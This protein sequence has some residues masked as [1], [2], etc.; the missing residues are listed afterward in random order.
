MEGTPPGQRTLATEALPLVMVRCVHQRLILD[1]SPDPHVS[2][3]RGSRAAKSEAVRRRTGWPAPGRTP[4]CPRHP[5]PPT[6]A[7]Q[8]THT[9]LS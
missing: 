6:R 8:V 9:P 1:P 2:S 7:L 5:R 3:E 4:N